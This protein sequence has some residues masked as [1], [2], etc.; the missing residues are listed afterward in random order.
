M[1]IMAILVV[2]GGLYLVIVLAALVAFCVYVVK[3]LRK[4]AAGQERAGEKLDDLLAQQS[5]S[6]EP[7][8]RHAEH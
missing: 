3:A 2:A 6:R 5:D 7:V 8:E 1:D 4:L